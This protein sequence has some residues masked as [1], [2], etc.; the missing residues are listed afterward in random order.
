MYGEGISKTGE[1]I[2]L[3]VKAGVVEKSGLVLLRQPAPGP[4]PRERQGFLKQ[5]PTS[6]SRIEQ[7]I[8]R[9]PGPD[10]RA[11]RFSGAEGRR[12]RGNEVA[13]AGA[14]RHPCASLDGFATPR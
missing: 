4:G 7:A 12:R 9:T 1:L 6:P 8:R 13:R 2:D 11:E 3:G 14:V 10:R 5:N